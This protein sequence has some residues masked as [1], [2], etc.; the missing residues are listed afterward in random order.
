MVGNHVADLVARYGDRSGTVPAA[1]T[2]YIAHRQ[3]YDYA[4][5][6]RAGN[7]D[8]EFVPD[9]VID[10]FC[11]LGPVPAH[12]AKLEQLAALGV[13]QVALYLM[14]DAIDETLAAYGDSVVGNVIA[15]G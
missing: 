7:P 11:L 4:H 9:E 2:D 6:G 13:D 1:L 15:R 8:T 10:R 12:L 5:H 14:H 3:G